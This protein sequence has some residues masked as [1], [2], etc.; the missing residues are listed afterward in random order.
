MTLPVDADLNQVRAQ[1]KELRRAAAGGSPAA[2]ARVATVRPDDPAGVTLRQAQRVIAREYGFAG[3]RELVAEL[4][5]GAGRQP[6]RERD[7]HRWFAVELNNTLWDLLDEC[8]PATPLADPER[9]LY[10]AY[11]ACFHWMC[12]GTVVNHGRGEYGIAWAA[13]AAGRH[14]LAA[15]HAR[16]YAELIDAE[17][18][19][20]ADWDRA[21]S[22]EISA[23]VAAACGAAD[24]AGRK[25]EA[26][27]LAEAVADQ[28]ERAVVLDRFA[29]EPWS[30][31]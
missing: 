6:V 16:R 31:V 2:L 5:T 1:A 11:A 14:E 3:W 15:H 28:E 20:F 7:L 10:Q 30:G 24:A 21:L 13:L 4:V 9:T 12:A 29:R 26:H 22:A 19:A 18:G 17:P 25:A 8:S 27:A 23:R